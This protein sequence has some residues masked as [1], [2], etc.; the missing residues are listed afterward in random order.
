[1]RPTT[2]VWGAFVFFEAKLSRLVGAIRNASDSG[3]G[4]LASLAAF[5]CGIGFA[6]HPLRQQT[7]R[8]PKLVFP[9]FIDDE[10]KI[11]VSDDV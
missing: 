3:A 7:V 4:D 8:Q 1:M 9:L 2:Q 11:R 10:R 5:A 6:I